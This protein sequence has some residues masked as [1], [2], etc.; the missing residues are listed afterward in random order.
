[1]SVKPEITYELFQEKHLEQTINCLVNVLTNAEPMLAAMKLTPSE[2]YP[3]A[4]AICSQAIPNNFSHIAK[5]SATSQII[6]TIIS[7]DLSTELP[8]EIPL[9]F[10]EKSFAIFQLLNE[11]HEQY[12]IKKKPVTSQ[13]FHILS[14]AVEEPYRNRNIA[15]N[16][17]RKNLEVARQE[18]FSEVIVEASGNISQHLFRKY[19]FEDICSIDY[20]T[21]KYQEIPVFEQI[22]EH[23]SCILMEKVF[24]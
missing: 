13:V 21:Y 1:M 6:G 12:L 17:I 7:D 14:L 20:Q 8:S 19:G 10:T 5:D 15:N 24:N 3:F 11:L 18:N 2:F 9:G 16:L 22:K 23:R 4:E